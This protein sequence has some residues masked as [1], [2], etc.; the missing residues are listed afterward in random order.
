MIMAF[1]RYKFNRLPFGISSALEV[2]FQNFHQIFRDIKGC[3]IFGDDIIIW[4]ST[5]EDQDERLRKV[6]KKAREHGVVSNR[7]KFKFRVR[8]VT[9]VSHKLFS[10][11]IEPNPERVYSLSNMEA[12]NDVISL[13]NFLG[14]S[15]YV[16]KF[17]ANLAEATKNLKQLTKA[18]VEWN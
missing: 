9:H 5:V 2:F 6:F 10:K 4:G 1:G 16:G 7:D 14:I 17:I 8:S 18:G 15:T 3:N 12:P 13:K 11:G